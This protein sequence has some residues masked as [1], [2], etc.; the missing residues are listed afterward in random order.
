MSEGSLL[1]RYFSLL[2]LFLHGVVWSSSTAKDLHETR[3]FIFSSVKWIRS[4][5]VF[6][7]YFCKTLSQL[8]SRV[9]FVL[10]HYIFFRKFK[11][12]STLSSSICIGSKSMI[13]CFFLF[14][15]AY[16]F[17]LWNTKVVCRPQVLGRPMPIKIVVLRLCK[18]NS[19]FYRFRSL[20]FIS[21]KFVWSLTSNFSCNSRR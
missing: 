17:C 15:Y 4:N 10:L 18:L 14:C 19:F 21:L 6:I 12:L 5:N 20:S 2:F 1:L 9:L 7:V 3:N 16:F 8:L 13:C 11:R